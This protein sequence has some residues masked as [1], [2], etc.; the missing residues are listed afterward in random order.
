MQFNKG[1]TA[2]ECNKLRLSLEQSLQKIDSNFLVLFEATK[3]NHIGLITE[4]DFKIK[5][6]GLY[7]RNIEEVI[8]VKNLWIET[9]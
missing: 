8:R 4:G 5:S 9:I 2:D 1:L 7:W 3:Y 6:I